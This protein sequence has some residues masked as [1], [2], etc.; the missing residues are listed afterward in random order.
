MNRVTRARAT[1]GRAPTAAPPAAEEVV[2]ENDDQAAATIP[3]DVSPVE[4]EHVRADTDP[5]IVVVAPRVAVSL[6]PRIVRAGKC[7][8]QDT[9]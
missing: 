1:E 6:R 4:I 5:T 9:R 8:S 3:E 7:Q 2:V